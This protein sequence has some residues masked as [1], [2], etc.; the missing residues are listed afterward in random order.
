MKRIV[1]LYLSLLLG[2]APLVIHGEDSAKTE[3]APNAAETTETERANSTSE[4]KTE[5]AKSEPPRASM[6]KFVPKDKISAD[7]AVSFPSDI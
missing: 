4:N 3:G 6:K 5:P 7:S 1:Y 2:C